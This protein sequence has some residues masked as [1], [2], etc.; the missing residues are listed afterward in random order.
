MLGLSTAPCHDARMATSCKSQ[1]APEAI[2][3]VTTSSYQ[4]QQLTTTVSG[5]CK[6]V[7]LRLALGCWP[8]ASPPPRTPLPPIPMS[9]PPVWDA[10]GDY[11]I[12]QATDYRFPSNF[13]DRQ[14]DS[15]AGPH[16]ASPPSPV[17]SDSKRSDYTS[18]EGDRDGSNDGNGCHHKLKL[19]SAFSV[20]SLDLLLERED[21]DETT[22]YDASY[23]RNEHRV[24]RLTKL[25][26]TRFA[27]FRR[28]IVSSSQEVWSQ[29]A[30]N[31]H[32]GSPAQTPSEATHSEITAA[33]RPSMHHKRSSSWLRFL[34]RT[35]TMTS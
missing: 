2:S 12:A 1:R 8:A 26:F 13:L 19:V 7:P 32:S 5:A 18:C 27:T 17:G 23:K 14:D 20:S 34:H 11:N 9:A 3:T 30:A 35:S 25:R 16:S 29:D 28:S 15:V 4:S 31:P 10:T 6:R 22:E 33:A 21:P 24:R